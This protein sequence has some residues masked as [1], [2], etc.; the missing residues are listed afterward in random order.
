VQGLPF[1]AVTREMEEGAADFELT[2]LTGG[3][4]ECKVLLKHRAPQGDY[5]AGE[6]SRDQFDRYIEALSPDTYDLIVVDGRARKHCVCHI[7]DNGYLR[8][9]GTVALFEAGRGTAG[10]LG[11]PGCW[12]DED[13]QPVVQR[14]L[15]LGARLVDGVGY[16]SWPSREKALVKQ[17]NPPIP[18]ECCLLTLPAGGVPVDCRSGCA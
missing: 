5:T 2:V 13:Y 9:N 4:C 12:G 15:R 17:K 14:M 10:W 6:G 3:N 16:L 8:P 7:L 1:Q 18:L 11:K